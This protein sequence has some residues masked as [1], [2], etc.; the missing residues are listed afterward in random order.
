M[1]AAPARAGGQGLWPFAAIY[2]LTCLLSLAI[3]WTQVASF[4]FPDPDDAL[5]LQ[6]VRDW[7]GGQSWFDVTQYR[8]N[9]PQGAPMHWSRIVDVPIAGVIVALTPLLG[10]GGAE[11]AALI[12][13]PLL[14]LGIAMAFVAII[15]HRLM[16][17]EHALLATL[18]VPVSV[19]VVHQLRPMRIDHHGWQVAIAA[20]ALL[21]AIHPRPIRSGLIVGGLAALWLA[22]SLEGLPFAAGLVALMAIRWLIDP[23]EG[24]RLAATAASLA[25]TS[26]ALFAAT[27][28]GTGWL[29]T[30]C[31]QIS[32][33]H[34]A[35]FGL[36]AAGCLAL[37]RLGSL[38]L[39]SRV[40]LLAGLG[41]AALA[42]LLGLAPQCRSGPFASLD[43]LV[44]DF[45]YDRVLEGLPI[46]SQTPTQAAIALAFPIVGLLGSWR[47]WRAAEG[48]KRL[49]WGC[50]LFLLVV[51]TLT[52]VAVE[53][54]GSVAN[55]LAVPGGA[56]LFQKALVRARGVSS[57]PQRIAA[58]LAALLLIG[59]SHVVSAGAIML[60]DQEPIEQLR[61]AATCMEAG[62]LGLLRQLPTSDI[63]APLDLSPAIVVL[64]RHRIVAS[65]HHRNDEAMRDTIRMFTSPPSEAREI[66]AARGID[67]VAIC[68]GLTEPQLYTAYAPDGLMAL[69]EQGRRPDWL[70]PVRIRGTDQL[71][72]WRIDA[73][74]QP[75]LGR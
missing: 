54:A 2:L 75:P 38:P 5:R 65:G 48:D 1:N 61:E 69:L 15:A 42:L 45:W 70:H 62:E 39:W 4:E 17:R 44:R 23:R 68:P 10:S 73:A 53:R 49:A 37:A 25:A 9:A 60:V 34:L 71:R 18:L 22:I 64:T 74:K 59:P 14:T 67:Y 36:G 11:T 26:L 32:P 52:T 6:Q 21:A 72:V 43:P 50:T 57:L 66:F 16:D 3:N 47:A 13:V 28:G 56:F 33:V 31:D 7:I 35:V 27:R 55:L 24:T 46:W 40:L 58:T 63:A 30:Y 41:G 51:A 20:G 8:M 19:A 12:L 29:V